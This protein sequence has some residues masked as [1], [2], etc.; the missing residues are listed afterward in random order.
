MPQSTT[1]P[2]ETAIIDIAGEKGARSARSLG[3]VLKF[4]EGRIVHGLRLRGRQ[5]TNSGAR[6]YRVATNEPD[7]SGF[8][9]FNGFSSSHT[10]K[11][12]HFH[13]YQLGETNPLN[14]ELSGSL[15]ATR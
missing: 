6:I 9:G 4:R 15:V 14:P 13:E 1:G 5:D 12:N 2:I 8:N 11:Q 7:N 10:E 3:R